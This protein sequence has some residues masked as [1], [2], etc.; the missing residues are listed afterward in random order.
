MS[1]IDDPRAD[2]EGVI[3]ISSTERPR[4]MRGE[5]AI[6]PFLDILYRDILLMFKIR[7]CY[8][9]KFY[10]LFPISALMKVP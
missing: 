1:D 2:V 3:E 8:R 10:Y 4:R 9:N 7:P 6:P 5:R